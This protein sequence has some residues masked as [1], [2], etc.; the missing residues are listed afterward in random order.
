MHGRAWKEKVFK[1]PFHPKP[2]RIVQFWDMVSPAEA[3]EIHSSPGISWLH[4]GLY[5][6]MEGFGQGQPWR[7]FQKE[8]CDFQ[9]LLQAPEMQELWGSEELG[10][11]KLGLGLCL[12]SLLQLR[13]LVGA[14]TGEMPLF[15]KT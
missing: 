7:H 1:G 3:G 6:G 9:H 5:S 2:L 8:L 11:P 12:L 15:S 14:D 13:L 10:T 4:L